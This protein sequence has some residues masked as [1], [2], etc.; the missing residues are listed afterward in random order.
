MDEQLFTLFTERFD[1]IEAQIKPIRDLVIQ[2]DK[3][4]GF[5]KKIFRIFAWVLVSGA[6]VFGFGKEMKEW[7]GL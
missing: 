4:I 3:D 5:V 1:R 2:H 6:T 7:L